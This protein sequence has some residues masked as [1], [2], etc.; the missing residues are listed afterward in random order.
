MHTSATPATV[1]IPLP[2]EDCLYNVFEYISDRKTVSSLLRTS[3]SFRE[4]V[5]QA[6]KVR[7]RCFYLLFTVFNLD[8]NVRSFYQKKQGDITVQSHYSFSGRDCNRIE[9]SS[10]S[11][12][13]VIKRKSDA[14]DDVLVDRRI[15]HD[16]LKKCVFIFETLSKDLLGHIFTHLKQDTIDALS[17]HPQ[18]LI[19]SLA[20]PSYPLDYTIKM[21]E[22]DEV[23]ALFRLDDILAQAK[24]R[25]AGDI[26]LLEQIA[27][28]VQTVPSC[29]G[30]RVHQEVALFNSHGVAEELNVAV[31]TAITSTSIKNWKIMGIPFRLNRSLR[32][33]DEFLPVSL[34][35]GKKEGDTVLL[36]YKN[37]T[38]R[39]RICK[40]ENFYFKTLLISALSES[41]NAPAVPENMYSPPLTHEKQLIMKQEAL[42]LCQEAYEK[43]PV[44][45]LVKNR[46][47]VDSIK[48]PQEEKE[49]CAKFKKSCVIF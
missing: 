30:G 7:I 36:S 20:P 35:I 41:L 12:T 33:M 28:I 17:E 8:S 46:S 16:F 21:D 49:L 38:A 11:L 5:I 27:K 4:M 29:D 25:E 18:A 34:F 2:C 22:P 24:V 6:Q 14:I 13:S 9:V 10:L 15:S 23:A 1:A 37:A 45:E 3:R 40:H 42:R 31:A 44:F 32:S 26:Y 47:F 39:L 43:K 19:D 48:L